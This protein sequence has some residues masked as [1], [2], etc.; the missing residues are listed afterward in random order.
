[1]NNYETKHIFLIGSIAALIFMPLI[2]L[3][4]PFIFQG[5]LFDS[6]SVWLLQTPTES[7][8][9]FTIG[10]GVLAVFLFLAFL[11]HRKGVLIT[12]A[13]SI[14]ALTLFTYGTLNFQS[15]STEEIVWSEP[16]S[17]KV[18]KYSWTDVSEV[19]LRVPEQRGEFHK[20]E[21]YFH[22]G[23]VVSFERNIDFNLNFYRF[24]ELRM[25]HNIPFKASNRM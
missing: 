20:M 9:M 14:I 4:G 3:L 19:V 25:Y 18:Q 16:G 17:L 8:W 22:D 24:Q 6:R 23:K 15:I 10:S 21:F 13:G 2:I 5:I 11:F 1:M 12:V 7:R